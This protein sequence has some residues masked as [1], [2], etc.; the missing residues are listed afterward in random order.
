[1]NRTH[2]IWVRLIAYVGLAI[3][4]QVCLSLAGK[5]YYLTQLTMALYY[6]IVVMGLSLLMGYAGQVSLGHGA[7][8]AIGGYT[9]AFLTTHNLGAYRDNAWLEMLDKLGLI[10]ARKNLY[11]DSLVLSVAPWAALIAAIV[12]AAVIAIVVGYP[13][14]RLR[15]HY[16]AMATLGFGLIVH[17]ILIGSP[18]LGAADGITGVPPLGLGAGLVVSGKGAVRVQN[19]YIAWAVAIAVLFLLR[20]IV[21]SRVGR[22]AR[23]IHE[24]EAAASAMGVNTA[25]L[26]LEVFV[27]S[28]VLAAMA[29]SLMAHYNEGIGPSE[30]SALKSVRY[31]ALV[32]AGGMANLEGA[33]I[34]SALLIFLSLRGW[35]GTYDNA[36]FGIILIAII[37]FAPRGPFSELNRLAIRRLGKAIESQAKPKKEVPSGAS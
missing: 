33:L 6:A 31:V 34:V 22:A 36:V 32:A 5:V 11:D 26:K 35:F 30:S 15:G 7:F 17:C 14:L 3:V 12:L 27:L 21:D 9:S 8:F 29:G 1:M 18:M 13:S 28:A 2:R 37:A 20:N 24:N 19:Y 25:K 16:L 23:A 4:L 10:V